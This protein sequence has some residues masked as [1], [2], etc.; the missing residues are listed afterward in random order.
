MS[1]FETLLPWILKWEGGVFTDDPDDRGGATKWGVIQERYDQYRTAQGKML[2]SVRLIHRNEVNDIYRQ[3]YW[4]AIDADKLPAPLDLAAFNVA[5]NSGPTRAIKWLSNTTGTPMERAEKLCDRYEQFYFSIVSA[6]NSQSK[7]LRGWLNRLNDCRQEI[8]ETP[9][10]APDAPAAWSLLL[11]DMPIGPAWANANDNYRA[12]YPAR[13]LLNVL[14]GAAIV[15]K[16]LALSAGQLV[17]DGKRLPVT[18][19]L[20]NTG[21]GGVME[22]WASVRDMAVWLGLDIEVDGK[23]RIIR[24]IRPVGGAKT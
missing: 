15:D 18:E 14:F 9:V 19:V 23:Q 3:Y 8:A 17:W 5:V 24:L 22:A 10:A 16:S 6:N 2:Q 20:R 12:Y 13:K 21:T 1:R 11:G 7:F 4:D